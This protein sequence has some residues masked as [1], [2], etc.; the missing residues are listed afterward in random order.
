MSEHDH[1]PSSAA[2]QTH[3]DRKSGR[4][5]FDND[6]RS[7]WEWQTATGV[8][9]RDVT[10]DQL[11]MLAT[12]TLEIDETPNE[13]EKAKVFTVT[14]CPMPAKAATR[15]SRGSRTA[16]KETRGL[17]AWLRLGWLG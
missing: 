7:V 14:R 11:S 3:T 17:A 8:F 1:E 5:V 4:A 15:S 10:D 9:T 6:G 12:V 13:A 16:K 2:A